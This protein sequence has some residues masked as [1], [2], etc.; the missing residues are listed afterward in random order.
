[1]P[2]TR[3]PSTRTGA[4]LRSTAAYHA[5]DFTGIRLHPEVLC[6]T[7]GRADIVATARGLGFPAR[8]VTPALTRFGR[9]YVVQLGADRDAGTVHLANTQGGPIRVELPADFLHR[10]TPPTKTAA[11]LAAVEADYPPGSLT[12]ALAESLA[13][14]LHLCTRAASHGDSTVTLRAIDEVIAP[15]LRAFGDPWTHHPTD[16]DPS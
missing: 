3:R 4:T 5:L 15:P 16:P 12:A 6:G 14:L 11:M 1:M 7:R 13:G 10:I 2:S 8:T 9:I